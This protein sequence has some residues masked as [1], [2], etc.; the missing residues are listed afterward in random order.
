MSTWNDFQRAVTK[1]N[2]NWSRDKKSAE[3]EIY[4]ED[5]ES[6]E[7]PAGSTTDIN[8]ETVEKHAGQVASAIGRDIATVNRA[9]HNGEAAKDFNGKSWPVHKWVDT[10]TGKYHI[11]VDVWQSLTEIKK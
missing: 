6:Y 1:H 7:F 11:P 9:A 4:R 10:E 2:L 8:T 3:Y 5:P